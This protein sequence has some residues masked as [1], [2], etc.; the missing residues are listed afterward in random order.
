VATSWLVPDRPCRVSKWGRL[1]AEPTRRVRM[2][3][4][5]GEVYAAIVGIHH[6]A[7][8]GGAEPRLCSRGASMTVGDLGIILELRRMVVRNASRN[9]ALFLR[10]YR[11]YWHL[12][13]SDPLWCQ[14][15]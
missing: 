14:E 7:A 9:R 4:R 6:P 8:R 10:V 5:A 11:L 1:I 13:L 15:G 12:Q 2:Y 3:R